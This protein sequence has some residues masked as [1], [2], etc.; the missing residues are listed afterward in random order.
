MKNDALAVD[1]TQQLIDSGVT[2]LAMPGGAVQLL[3]KSGS[4]LFS[5]EIS[6]IREKNLERL[7]SVVTPRP[8][9]KATAIRSQLANT[10]ASWYEP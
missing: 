3:G 1:I 9:G 5:H 4:V 8:S 10:Q 2:I 6:T 7:G